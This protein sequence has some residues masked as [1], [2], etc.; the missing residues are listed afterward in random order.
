MQLLARHVSH[1]ISY[2]GHQA[3]ATGSWGKHCINAVTKPIPALKSKQ[4]GTPGA[5]QA[6]VP[7][8]YASSASFVEIFA[9][10]PTCKGSQMTAAFENAGVAALGR[11]VMLKA[12]TAI[13]ASSLFS[14]FC[15]SSCSSSPWV[16]RRRIVDC[17]SIVDRFSAR[18]AARTPPRPSVAYCLQAHEFALP[19]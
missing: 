7:F 16:G 2:H 5:L 8:L 19:V 10:A 11:R 9:G 15:G 14:G 17:C 1:A 12:S 6:G 13:N 4:C 3:S 18:N